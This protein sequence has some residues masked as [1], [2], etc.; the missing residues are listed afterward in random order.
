[1]VAEAVPGCHVQCCLPS[2]LAGQVN[3]GPVS[4][5]ELGT[6]A[7]R[8]GG[9]GVHRTDGFW[10]MRAGVGALRDDR[11]E[12]MWGE[13][14]DQA[15]AGIPWELLHSEQQRLG[16]VTLCPGAHHGYGTGGDLGNV[17]FLPLTSIIHEWSS[18][19]I[20]DYPDHP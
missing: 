13:D 17:S 14:G 15:G 20:I 10:G 2:I 8:W 12:V 7:K 5:Q 16:R 18:L 4:Q 11:W 9:W 3:S 19:T 6:S 1:M